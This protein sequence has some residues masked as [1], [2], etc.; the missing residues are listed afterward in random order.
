MYL[1]A[2][3]RAGT[4][5][6]LDRLEQ[7]EDP[8][9]KDL[10]YCMQL[11]K[12]LYGTKQAARNWYLL[13]SETLTSEHHGF[14]ASKIDPCLFVRDDCIVLVYTDDC[15]I[16][17]RDQATIDALKKTLTEVDGFLHRTEGTLNDFLGVRMHMHTTATGHT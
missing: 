9:F 2:S 8:R 12:N 13:L 4:T 7:H 3:H 10:Q 16:L 14:K 5:A 6:S 1:L 17:G 15:I 11:V